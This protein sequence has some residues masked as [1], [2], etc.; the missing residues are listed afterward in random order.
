M[1]R[2]RM[3][4]DIDLEKEI[5]VDPNSIPIF[6]SK[7]EHYYILI[8][9]IDVTSANIIKQEMLSRGGDVAIHKYAI[10]HK[11]DKTNILLIGTKKQYDL[12]IKKLSTMNYWDIPKVKESLDKVFKNIKK[13]KWEYTINNNRNLSLGENSKIMGIL[14][15]TPDSFHAPSRIKSVEQAIEQAK[16]MIKEGAEILDIGAE[17][18]RPGSESVELKEEIERVIPVIKELRSEFSDIVLSVDTYKSEVAKL[19]IENGADII[20]DISGM[21]FD[22]NMVN[23]V[24]EAKLPIV[25]MHIKGTPKNMQKN[26]YYENCIS[27][28][29][30]YFEERIEYANKH[31]IDQI[32]IDPG[33]GFGKRVQD[34]LNLSFN[35]SEFRALGYPILM[36]HSRKSTIGNILNLPD[37]KDRLEGTLA[38]TSYYALKNIEIIRVHDVQENYRVVKTIEAL[39]GYKKY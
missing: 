37:T 33:F 7:M 29:M 23:V 20:N 12:L 27:E 34:N 28:L 11:I 17:S 13:R 10:N 36:G 8:E 15:I 30:E 19:A 5:H 1:V 26:P 24:A 39:R 32:I 31:G 16:K 3:F 35:I 18:T 22:K 14:N 9:E 6:K 21:R 2:I 38:L 4:E 25:I